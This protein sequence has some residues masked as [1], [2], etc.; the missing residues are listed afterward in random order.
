MLRKQAAGCQT[1]ELGLFCRTVQNLRFILPSHMIASGTTV[2]FSRCSEPPGTLCVHR[3]VKKAAPCVPECLSRHLKL[4]V[5]VC[6][7]GGI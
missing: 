6:V 2:A 7:K 5:C 4:F 3:M 1:N